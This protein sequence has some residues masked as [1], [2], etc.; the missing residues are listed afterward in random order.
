MRLAVFRLLVAAGPQ[1]MPAGEISEALRVKQNTLSTNLGVLRNAGI[2][3]S[4]RQGR[5]IVYYADLEG[6]RD[7]LA[8]LLEDC[9]GGRKSA[10]DPLINDI[11]TACQ[12]A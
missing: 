12:S 6:L 5:S 7:L 1:G 11:V 9:C 2:V 8:F 3:R 10:C 4:Q